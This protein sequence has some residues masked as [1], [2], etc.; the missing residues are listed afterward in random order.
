MGKAHWVDGHCFGGRSWPAVLHDYLELSKD[1]P[2]SLEPLRPQD[3]KGIFD[4]CSRW[5]PAGDGE[6]QRAA[7]ARLQLPGRIKF[8][9]G[10]VKETV[11][12][13]GAEELEGLG[14]EILDSPN[15]NP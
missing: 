1:P 2:A 7:L 13:A 12:K 5:L 3:Q 6:F 14:A 8:L 4:N 15:E 10:A 9:L 11:G